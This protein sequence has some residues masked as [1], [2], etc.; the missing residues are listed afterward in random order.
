MFENIEVHGCVITRHPEL[1]P[2]DV[3]S[4]W[5]NALVIIERQPDDF[6]GAV[7]VAVGSDSHGRLLEMMAA[8]TAHG[9]VLV[10]HA[11]TP[12]SVKTLREVGL[13]R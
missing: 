3:E 6:P 4:A 1:K 2:S 12:P 7:L 11:M 9:G 13:K 8:A 5:R 10:F